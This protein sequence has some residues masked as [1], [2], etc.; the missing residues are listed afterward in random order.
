LAQIQSMQPQIRV[1]FLQQLQQANPHLYQ[2]MQQ[3]YP[4]IFQCMQQPHPVMMQMPQAVVPTHPVTMQ[5][6]QQ[7]AGPNKVSVQPHTFRTI[8]QTFIDALSAGNGAA[9]TAASAQ[10]WTVCWSIVT[11]DTAT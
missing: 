11:I 3:T 9:T 2:Y 7:A 8:A 1:Q 4:H 6:M 5:P 10:F